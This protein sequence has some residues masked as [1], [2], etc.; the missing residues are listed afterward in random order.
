MY[1]YLHILHVLCCTVLC[2]YRLLSPVDRSD[3]LM[4]RVVLYRL[5]YTASSP[6]D[7]ALVHVHL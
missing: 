2:T 6:V 5:L 1:T 3:F 7:R 4:C